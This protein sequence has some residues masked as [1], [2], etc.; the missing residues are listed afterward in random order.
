[1]P[2][3]QHNLTRGKLVGD[4]PLHSRRF[5]EDQFVHGMFSA[6]ACT[7][8]GSQQSDSS[9]LGG[10]RGQGVKRRPERNVNEARSWALL[11][12]LVYEIEGLA[13]LHRIAGWC[14]QTS[15]ACSRVYRMLAAAG[16]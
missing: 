14:V 5:A 13:L 1:M 10:L 4:L 15:R 8:S 12:N 7:V 9:T 16:G 6:R 2:K 11:S 3:L